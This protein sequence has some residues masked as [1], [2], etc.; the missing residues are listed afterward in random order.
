MAIFFFLIGLEVK[1]EILIGELNSM[2]KAALPIF[3]AIGGVLLPVGLFLYFNDN[4]LT[5]DGWGI[6]MATDIA[7]SLAILTVLG[8]RVPIGLKVFLTALAIVDDIAAVSIIAI[9]YSENID[10]LILLYAAIPLAFLFLLMYRQTY[11]KYLTILFGIIIWVLFLKSGIHPT[12]AGILVAFT[13]PLSQKYGIKE[14]LS[15]IN[16]KVTELSQAENLNVPIASKEQIYALD[17]IEEWTA[18]VRSPLQHLENQL[19]DWVSYV[20]IPIFAFAN[21]GVAFGADAT[22]DTGIMLHLALA[23][24]IGKSVGISLFTF[25]SVKFKLAKLPRGIKWIHIIGVAFLAGIGFTMSIFIANLAFPM[26][27]ELIDASKIGV[28]F[29][30]VLAGLSG[31]L[32]LRFT[33]KKP[34]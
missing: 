7:F 8:S 12:I 15:K 25:I 20:I 28:I 33:L 6:P 23:L 30:S 5:S 11:N 27:K 9:F 1:R 21:A 34:A 14:S 18:K 2:K 10:W 19:H 4:P 22:A 26:H 16:E 29:G 31:Y 3:A 13:V 32:I 24:L 17:E